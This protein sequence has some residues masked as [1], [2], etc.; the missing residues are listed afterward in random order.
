MMRVGRW[1]GLIA[2][3]LLLAAGTARAQA[4]VEIT[5]FIDADSLTVYV[6]SNQLA[7][8][9]DMGLQ[10][11][12]GDQRISYFLQTFAAFQVI[13]FTSV[14][15]PICLRL[16]RESGGGV[17]EDACAPGYTLVQRRSP[18]DVFWYDPAEQ[19]TRTILLVQGIQ[20]V[21][22]L[23]FCPAGQVVCPLTY[24]PPTFTPTLTPTRT[25]TW[26]LTPT[27][28]LSPTLTLTPT[29]TPTPSPTPD[30]ASSLVAVTRN[31]DWTPIIQ[32]F[33]GV[34]MAL[35]PVG[36]FMMG[37]TDEEISALTAQDGDF[38]SDEAPQHETCID[39]PFW[40]DV[41][42]VTQAQ[43][44]TFGGVAAN[45][46]RFSG[47]Q[48][49][50]ERITWF[51]ARAYC[52]DQRGMRL[53]TEAEWEFAARGVDALSYPWGNTFDG[54]NVVYSSNSNGQTAAVGSRPGGVSWV[55]ALDLSGNVWEWVSTIY[56][57]GR[58]PYPYNA[59]DGR[60]DIQS[61]NSARV[62]RGGSWNDT[63]F[64]VR[65]ANRHR[66]TPD[67]R[68]NNFGFRCVSS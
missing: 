22:V 9:Q 1:I 38:F 33:D 42:E 35:V 59:D 19:N 21:N 58:F 24:Q 47:D 40:I 32:D 23:A 46:S 65:A 3:G 67:N 37:S 7:S 41:T 17:L 28:T 54:A 52:E 14:P 29:I 16:E 2:V 51:E 25:P 27:F 45:G 68:Y 43:F 12:I 60:E 61:T 8:L 57:Q 66:F 31:A 10:V 20:F 36:C 55:G 30:I 34:P 63:N 15:T 49:P 62:L 18:S 64:N 11:V 50:V 6:P 44:R 26:T 4:P 39:T 56:D 5:L 13:P 53:P 48:R